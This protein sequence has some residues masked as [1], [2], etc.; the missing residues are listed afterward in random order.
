M[1][2]LFVVDDEAS[3]RTTLALLLR[4]RGHRV[5]EA[6]GRRDYL[7]AWDVETGKELRR[8]PCAMPFHT[9]LSPAYSCRSLPRSS[10]GA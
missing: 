9:A 6:G 10:R 1:A 3:A 8:F 5:E 7:V 4:R 2:H